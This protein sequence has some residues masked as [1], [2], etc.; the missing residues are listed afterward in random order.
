[1][2]F[3]ILW[4]AF[5]VPL[6]VLF[7]SA[8]PLSPRV[9]EYNIVAR[10]DPAAKTLEGQETIT[11]R[12]QGDEDLPSLQFHLYWNAFRD[13]RS[14]FQRELAVGS[15]DYQFDERRAGW[16]DISSVRLPDGAELVKG[17]RYL[18]PDDRNAEDRTV[19]EVAL[20]EPA[21]AGSTF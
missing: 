6:G 2:N 19:A 11:Y 5:C 10:L 18:H 8:E 13:A 7:L 1:M 21:P 9:V 4:P 20:P 12:H 15:P 14:T 17:L 16:I 3:R